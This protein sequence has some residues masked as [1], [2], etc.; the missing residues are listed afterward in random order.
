MDKF[1][2]E[3]NV[4]LIQNQLQDDV[5]ESEAIHGLDFDKVTEFE[6]HLLQF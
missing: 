6:M 5:P 2:L 4:K 3:N 1:D